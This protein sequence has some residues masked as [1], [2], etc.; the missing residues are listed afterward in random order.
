[1]QI[2]VEIAFIIRLFIIVTRILL[3]H[4]P[5]IPV[6]HAISVIIYLLINKFALHTQLF[7]TA[8]F[9]NEILM[10]QDVLLVKLA[11]I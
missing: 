11:I 8:M 4:R 7:T 6:K 1:M 2:S 9:I 3:I 5:Q 10:V